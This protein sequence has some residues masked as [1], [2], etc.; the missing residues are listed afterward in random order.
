ML[1]FIIFI[2]VLSITVIFHEF[3][4]FIAAKRMGVKIESF[5][6]GFGPKLFAKEIRKTQYSIC[7]VPLGG[8]V[9]LAGDNLAEFK[10]EPFE[11]LSKPVGK[12]AKIIILGPLLNYVMAFFCFWVVFYFGYPY[13]TPKVGEVITGFGAEEAGIKQKD[14]IIAIDDNPIQYWEQLQKIIQ[15]KKGNEVVQLSV[16]RNNEL[17]KV[18]VKIKESESQDLLGQKKSV[19]IIGIRPEGEVIKVRYNLKD[20]LFMAAKKLLELTLITYKAIMR[21]ILGRLSFKDSV[22]GPLGMFYLTSQAAQLGFTAIL[23]FVAVLNLSLSVFNLLPI[24][25]LDGG[26]LLLLGIEKAKGRYLNPR[27]DKIVNQ[28][29]LSFILLLAAFI[30]YNDLVRFGI[31]EKLS[32]FLKQ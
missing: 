8:Y 31:W 1:S 26:H 25:V 29:G 2:L 10:G 5:S 6:L 21:M 13:L 30:F 7:A 9:K 16:L 17:Y 18:K 19:G 24:P 4:H 32:H 22:T 23:H 12:R 27:T 28:M 20:A 15:K 3:G 11:Y 14:K